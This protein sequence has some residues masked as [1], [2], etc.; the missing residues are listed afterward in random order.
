MSIT[1]TE[2]VTLEKHE[3]G[4]CGGVYAITQRVVDHHRE[5]GGFWHCPYCQISWGYG[6]ST[7]DK[8]RKEL[9]EKAKLLT[10]AKCEALR[11]SQLLEESDRKLSESNRKL[12]RVKNG[13]CPC[14]NRTF[15]N[16]HR[17]M[18]IKHPEAA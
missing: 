14:C 3:C 1:F 12:N 2:S 16:L 15:Q 17:H 10:A 4:K 13:V 6:E 7:A 8:L 5:T 9:D 18:K 11:Q